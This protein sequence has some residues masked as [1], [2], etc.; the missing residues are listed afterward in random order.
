MANMLRNRIRNLLVR[1]YSSIFI[2]PFSLGILVYVSYGLLIDQL[3][4]YYDDWPLMLVYN[5]AGPGKFFSIFKHSRPLII[6]LY[7][8]TTPILGDDPLRWQ[9]LNLVLRWVLAVVV[10]W[11]LRQIWPGRSRQTA[12]IAFVFAVYPSFTQQFVSVMYS[13]IFVSFIIHMFSFGAMLKAIRAK[14][15]IWG[16]LSV[17]GMIYSIYSIEYFVGWELVRPLLIWLVIRDQNASSKKHFRQTLVY[18]LPFLAILVVYALWRFFLIPSAIYDP[19]LVTDFVVNPLGTLLVFASTVFQDLIEVIFM[20]FMQTIRIA[21]LFDFGSGFQQAYSIVVLSISGI[22]M[23][24]FTWLKVSNFQQNEESPSFRIGWNGEA[25]LLGLISMVCAGIP[26]WLVPFA[27]SLEFP[28]NRMTLGMMLG[29][30]I[31]FVSILELT[32]NSLRKRSAIFAVLIGF[33]AG[34]HYQTAESFRIEWV[35]QKDFIWQLAWRVPSIE[36]G[37]TIMTD[38]LPFRYTDDEAFTA[39]VNLVYDSESDQSNLNYNLIT[40]SKRF[41]DDAASIEADDPILMEIGPFNFSGVASGSFPVYYSGNDCLRVLH[42]HD[43]GFSQTVP[44]VLA[45]AIPWSNLGMI[46]PEEGYSDGVLRHYFGKE[47]GQSWCYY[48]SKAAL[49]AQHGHWQD[50]VELGDEAFERGRQFLNPVELMP[51]IEGYALVGNFEQVANLTAQ[52]SKS[53]NTLHPRLCMV[54]SRISQTNSGD[55]LQSDIAGIIRG[56]GCELYEY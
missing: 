35:L 6:W 9:F 43:D 28:D 36:P 30:S 14:S 48:Y 10:W 46:S 27:I 3:G 29:G 24:L 31:V 8:I 44:G 39:L 1:D 52:V 18:W 55:D 16:V 15:L 22:V 19:G 32:V 4:Y 37:T 56:L 26:A 13:H 7:S 12:W 49:A 33:A 54:W 53:T 47:P 21:R 25:M 42:P 45:E 17:A 23:L 2:I 34:F 51:F 50:V 5:Q 38:G 20:A 41:G 11:F 40:V